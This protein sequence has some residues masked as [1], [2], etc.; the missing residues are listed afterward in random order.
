VTAGRPLRV[1]GDGRASTHRQCN[2]Q[3]SD[4]DRRAGDA[5]AAPSSLSVAHGV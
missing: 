4:G 1:P 5:R 3:H 2:G